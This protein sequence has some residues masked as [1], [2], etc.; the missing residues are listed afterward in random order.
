MPSAVSQ[1]LRALAGSPLNVLLVAAPI[2][3]WLRWHS[4]VSIWV[5]VRA[6]LSL[7]PPAGLSG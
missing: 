4:G 3:L 1:I 7:V 6:A 5:F 2:S